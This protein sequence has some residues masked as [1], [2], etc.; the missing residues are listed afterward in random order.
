MSQQE[1]SGSSNA[2][3]STHSISR[4]RADDVLSESSSDGE[5]D[6]HRVESRRASASRHWHAAAAAVMESAEALAAASNAATGGA[7]GSTGA[8]MSSAP[9]T[10]AAA[11]GSGSG[12]G[13]A[14]GQVAQ[15]SSTAAA[16]HASVQP[17]SALA[18]GSVPTIAEALQQGGANRASTSGASGSFDFAVASPSAIA[19]RSATGA[20]GSGSAVGS[21]MNANASGSS[22]AARSLQPLH[23]IESSEERHV[24]ARQRQMLEQQAGAAR[25]QAARMA[26]HAPLQHNHHFHQQ[27]SHQHLHQH[28]TQ[29]QPQQQQQP[30]QHT[31]LP[32]FSTPSAPFHPHTHTHNH[33][34]GHTHGHGHGN[35]RGLAQGSVA[36]RH[37]GTHS[38]TAN[39]ATSAL[40]AANPRAPGARR[41]AKRKG[42]KSKGKGKEASETRSSECFAMGAIAFQFV[43]A[44][45]HERLPWA[46][47][48]H[49]I[50]SRSNG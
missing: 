30:G 11:S 33:S 6:Y 31:A 17:Q 19:S 25:Q 12:S 32:G 24:R 39:A 47:T 34:H 23:Q 8:A 36:H 16:P 27:H 14:A 38:A 44:C 18:T 50:Q 26:S 37:G 5:A 40:F 22:S 41:E 4:R 28:Q 43:L 45:T 15:G 48:S 13:S 42:E 21:S 20:G 1:D 9:S 2:N 35:A 46:M 10:S 7:S 49:R 29:Q 3:R